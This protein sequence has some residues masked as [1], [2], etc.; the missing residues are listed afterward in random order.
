V[1]SRLLAGRAF[2]QATSIPSIRDGIRNFVEPPKHLP[3]VGRFQ[4]NFRA[5]L[6]AVEP[7]SVV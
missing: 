6:N 2:P 4:M 3:D 7:R 5:D 1:G